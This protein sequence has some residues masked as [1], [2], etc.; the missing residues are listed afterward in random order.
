[1]PSYRVGDGQVRRSPWEVTLLMKYSRAR[2]GA[3]VV[4]AAVFLAA[5]DGDD[6]PIGE[7]FTNID[8]A[9]AAEGV[10]MGNA[11]ISGVAGVDAFFG[12]VVRF[13]A[14]A[15]GVAGGIQT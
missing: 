6:G 1:M 8:L 2:G 7:C 14:E 12:S 10:A 15:R 3:V 5:C 9:C 4:S 13:D 11:N